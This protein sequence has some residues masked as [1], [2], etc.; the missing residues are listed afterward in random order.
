MR[1]VNKKILNEKIDQY[2]NDCQSKINKL[3]INKYTEETDEV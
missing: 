1:K 2:I 3:N